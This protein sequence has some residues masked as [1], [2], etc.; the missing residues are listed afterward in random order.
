MKITVVGTGY[1]GLVTGSCFAEM[2]NDV[3]CVDKDRDKIKNLEK[4]VIPIYEPGLDVVLARY[5][6]ALAWAQPDVHAKVIAVAV[7]TYD[8]SEQE[9]LDAVEH[10]RQVTGLPAADPVRFGVGPLAEAVQARLE[11][12]KAGGN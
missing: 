2:G 9:A 11:Q 4:G 8:L 6:K 5:E 3:Y 7:A 10:A 1:V 12:Y